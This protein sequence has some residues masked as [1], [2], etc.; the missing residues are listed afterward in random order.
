VLRETY[1]DRTRPTHIVVISDNGV[2][3]M[4]RPT[5]ELGTPGAAIAAAALSAARAGGTLLLRLPTERM[6]LE[7]AELATGWDV[8]KVTNWDELVEFA[9]AF[10]RRTYERST[11]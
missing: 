8:H 6:R 9:A 5:D 1:R 7:I 3:T 10:S 4:F 2:D 11:T